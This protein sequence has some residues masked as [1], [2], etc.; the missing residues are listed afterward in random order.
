MAGLEPGSHEVTEADPT[1]NA[2]TAKHSMTAE[3]AAMEHA[4]FLARNEHVRRLRGNGTCSV[5]LSAQVV[6]TTRQCH[7]RQRPES[8]LTRISVR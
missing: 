1:T 2:I 3:F 5:T 8:L 6:A 4:R 7:R